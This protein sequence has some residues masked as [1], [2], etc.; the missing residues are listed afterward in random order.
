MEGGRLVVRGFGGALEPVAGNACFYG[1]RGG[2]GFL[3]GIAGERF[4]VRNSGAELVVEGTGDHA[5]E[6]MTAGFVAILGPVGKNFASGMSGGVA[7][8]ATESPFDPATHALPLGPTSCRLAPARADD[9]DSER[10]RRLLQ[11]HEAATGS[12]TARRL[13]D[14]WPTSLSHFAKLAPPS[15]EPA[16]RESAPSL[17]SV[18]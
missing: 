8:V 4:A 6:Y 16:A 18:P 11:R 7:F 2:E 15:E 13:L 17:V 9:P 12:L 1:A 10:L 14:Q 5:C 3:R